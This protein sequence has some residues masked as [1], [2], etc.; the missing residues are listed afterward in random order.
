MLKLG[1]GPWPSQ[2]LSYA[3]GPAQELLPVIDRQV[4]GCGHASVRVMHHL[5]CLANLPFD[6]GAICLQ[7]VLAGERHS[8]SSPSV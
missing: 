7:Q 4:R 3:I 8:G 2:A 5:L 1:N 6:A